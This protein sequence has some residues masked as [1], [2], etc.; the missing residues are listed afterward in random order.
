M[1]Q[2][3]PPYAI[4]ASRHIHAGSLQT[5]GMSTSNVAS[6]H[7]AKFANVRLN[8]SGSSSR[9]PCVVSLV[10]SA[11]ASTSAGRIGEVGWSDGFFLCSAFY[12]IAAWTVMNVFSPSVAPMTDSLMKSS[13]K[14]R[15][16]IAVGSRADQRQQHDPAS[17]SAEQAAREEARGGRTVYNGNSGLYHQEQRKSHGRSYSKGNGNPDQKGLT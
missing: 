9:R 5:E 3:P 12:P 11:R 17:T 8:S 1:S 7:E 4:V 2:G 10:P 16:S 14:P 13:P 6:S 15:P